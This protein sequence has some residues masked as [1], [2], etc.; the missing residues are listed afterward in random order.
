M[1]KLILALCI[2]F[3]SLSAVAAPSGRISPQSGA[4]VPEN[5]VNSTSVYLAPVDG[6][7][8]ELW[9]GSAWASYTY[10]GELSLPLS[11]SN[12]L[13]GKNY[14]VFE[15]E[16][17]GSV[18]LC[19][20]PAWATNTLRNEDV[21]VFEGRIVNATSMACINGATTYTVDARK[22]HLRGG[23][24]A[25]ANGQTRSTK[26]S[27]LVW[28]AYR[29]VVVPVSRVDTTNSWSYSAALFR[30]ANNNSANQIEVFNGVSGRPVDIS[31]S[32]YVVNSSGTVRAAFVGI[33]LDSS[34]ADSSQQKN[35]C[36]ASNAFPV[37]PCWARFVGY[38]G[39]GY[40]ELRWIE[41]G[42]GNEAQ[43]W[44]GDNNYADYGYQTGLV[45]YVIQ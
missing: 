40:H 2:A 27:R 37:L 43:T 39:I 8:T 41:R 30:Q 16:S 29:P 15:I 14:D 5:D 26:S 1:R 13:A 44:I 28:D 24:R 38:I 12:H 20:G 31:A 42:S 25:H 3:L 45:G 11:A 19:T 36:A 17:A 34:T 35:P 21:E 9:S 18:I 4:P 33:G 6:N 10:S 32:A 7:S 23:F 22:G